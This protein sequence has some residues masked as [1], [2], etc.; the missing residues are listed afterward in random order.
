ME[1][2]Y[3]RFEDLI[4]LFS[5]G[6]SADIE[7]YESSWY[8]L[9]IDQT[10]GKLISRY[11]MNSFAGSFHPGC[12][13]AWDSATTYEEMKRILAKEEIKDGLKY[14]SLYEDNWEEWLI[15]NHFV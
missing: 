12:I 15:N 7:R 1:K 5:Y 10:N 9:Y 11:L 8:N 2:L 4:Y 3:K 13:S 6:E 14:E